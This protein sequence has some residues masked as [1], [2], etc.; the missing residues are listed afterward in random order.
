MVRT[1]EGLLPFTSCEPWTRPRLPYNE[2]MPESACLAMYLTDRPHVL[3]PA[4]TALLNALTDNFNTR[5][6]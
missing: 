6:N 1:R 4:C 3:C 5:F 2:G